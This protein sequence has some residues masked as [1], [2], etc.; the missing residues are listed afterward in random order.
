MIKECENLKRIFLIRHGRQSST[1][2]NVN[3]PLAKEGER[4]AQLVG[5]RLKNYD[6][7]LLYSSKL[8][9]AVQTAQ[10][11]N[12]S[13]GVEYRQDDDLRELSFGDMEGIENN[14]LKQQY[15]DFFEESIKMEKDIPYPGGEC[16]KDGYD[17]AMPVIKRII[18][19]TEEIN[20]NNI[21]IVTHG[22]LIRSILSGLVGEQFAKRLI[23]AKSL[24]NCSITEIVYDEITDG[25]TIERFNDYAHIEQE[26]ELLRKNIK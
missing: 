13:L 24:E 10:I 7:G 23:F 6:I 25:F 26:Q 16:S 18:K 1:L 11:I 17:R 5:E 22:G 3:V 14:V 12:E 19:E 8:I 4:Q 15:K 21:A 9:R 20:V 2:C